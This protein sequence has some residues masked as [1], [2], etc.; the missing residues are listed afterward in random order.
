MK[1]AGGNLDSVGYIHEDNY[2]DNYPAEQRETIWHDFLRLSAAYRARID[3]V[4]LATFA[5]MEPFRM[6]RLAGIAGIEGVFANYG[7]THLTTTQ[8]NLLTLSSGKPVFRSMNRGPGGNTPFT[9]FS[10]SDAV[11]FMV[12]EVRRWNAGAGLGPA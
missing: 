1:A 5:E 9:P 12:G 7:R 10:R 4:A 11:Q 3:S 2:G 8:E 6:A